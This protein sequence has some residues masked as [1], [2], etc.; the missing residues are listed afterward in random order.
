MFLS[1]SGEFL[2]HGRCYSMNELSILSNYLP[3]SNYTKFQYGL[4]SYN[5]RMFVK[6]INCEYLF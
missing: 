5:V 3:L 1:I 2:G 4:V 6:T